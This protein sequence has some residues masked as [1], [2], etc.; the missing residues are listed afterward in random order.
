MRIGILTLPLRY[1]YGGILQAWAL[2]T[3][4]ARM[5]HDVSV[6]NPNIP[7]H[8]MVF[9]QPLTYAKRIILNILGRRVPIF[10][11]KSYYNTDKIIGVNMRH[12]IDKYIKEYHYDLLTDINKDDFDMF[13]VGSDQIWRPEYFLGRRQI[14]KAFLSFTKGWNVRRISYAASFGKD[15]IDN[16]SRRNIKACGEALRQFDAVSVREKSGVQIC[17]EKFGVYAIQVLDPTMLLCKDDYLQLIK[18]FDLPKSPGN[19]H[20]YFL[21][22]TSDKMSLVDLI[23]KERNLVPFR[24]NSKVEDYSANIKD[25]IQPPLEQWLR[26]FCDSD[27]II[28]DSFHACVFSIIFNKQFVVYVNENRGT[29]RYESLL[30]PLRLTNR[31]VHKSEDFHCIDLDINYSIVNKRL[32]VLRERS[33][34]YL[35]DSVKIYVNSCCH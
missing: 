12:F 9:R 5:G 11:E 28:T 26:A 27:F 29:A 23:A 19:L 13:V 35:C 25:R 20:Y 16:W 10:P 3:V 17:K 32:D 2:Q 7:K 22:E 33:M 14:S 24:V 15:N 18:S 30:N 34:K 21:D 31:I 8:P 1:N 4:M 6:L